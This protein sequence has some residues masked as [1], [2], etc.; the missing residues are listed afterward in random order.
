M[1]RSFA[2]IVF[3]AF[4]VPASACKFVQRSPEELMTASPVVFRAQVVQVN[5]AVVRTLPGQSQPGQSQP[6]ELIEA[7]YKVLEVLKGK[8]SLTG[9]VRDGPADSKCSLRLSVGAEYLFI[10]DNQ[11]M[12]FLPT[13]SFKL[14][15]NEKAAEQR[16]QALRKLAANEAK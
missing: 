16:L 9:I 12:V 5:A 4:A 13:G 15:A 1:I 8:P 11:Q 6:Q 7:R 2:F 3:L 14:I 10:P